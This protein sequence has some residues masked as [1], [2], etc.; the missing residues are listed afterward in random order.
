MSVSLHLPRQLRLH[1][2][3]VACSLILSTHLPAHA[4]AQ[5]LDERVQALEQQQN[6]QSEVNQVMSDL[7]GKINVS[8]F[9]S[10]RGGMIDDEE[11]IY[12]STTD[13][14]LSFSEESVA[15]LQVDST[16][17]EKL[18]MSMQIK[19]ATSEDGVDLEWGY[20]EY[21]FE[22]DLKL[23]AGRLR[24][25]GFMLSEFLDVGYAYPWAQVPYEVYGW[26]PF[27]HYE[28]LDLR[29]WTSIGGVDFRLNPH[30]GTTTDQQLAMGKLEFTGQSSEFAGLDIQATYDIF[31][32][33][34]GYSKYRFTLTN[35]VL[36]NFIA[37]V[38]EGVTIVPDIPPYVDGVATLGLIAYVEDVLVG[39]GA[40]PGSGVLTD[41]ILGLQAD[42][43]PANDFM[44]PVLQGES[45]SL[46]AQ[47]DSY[48]NIPTMNGDQDGEFYGVGFSAD[49]GEF[50]LMSEVSSSSI[51][52]IYPDVDSGYVMFGY[53]FGNW[54]PH[55][56]FAK[57]YTTNDNERPDIQSFQLNEMIWNSDP[58]LAMLADGLAGYTDGLLVTMN[59]IR[60]EQETFTLGVRWD[61]L[62]SLAIKAEVFQVQL[63]NGSYGF[64]IPAAMLGLSEVNFLAFADTE[65]TAFPAP[66]DSVS[67]V[68]LSLDLVF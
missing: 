56:T 49:N 63:K 12:L 27:S 35:S 23:R 68:R 31:T 57:M 11:V 45:A 66:Q 58:G 47:L 20:L 53:R 5:T 7:V 14:N 22:P 33:R 36:D 6:Q 60:L 54:M 55:F 38:V 52:G 61:P 24:A 28:G 64:A 34:A 15:G 42:G 59:I 9:V 29:Y 41:T 62:E 13:D 21:A 18:A 3:A 51:Q 1:P 50:L 19:A 10:V 8:G 37:P 26:L 4:L 16:I 46:L 2:L 43:N 40:T 65:A 30:A 17:S 44:I 32:L 39:D 67:G 25:P 48:R